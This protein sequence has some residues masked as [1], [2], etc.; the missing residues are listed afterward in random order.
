MKTFKEYLNE[1][2]Q[3]TSIHSLGWDRADDFTGLKIKHSEKINIAKKN[4]KQ[5][6]VGSTR[7]AFE[8]IFKGKPTVMKIAKNDKG[9]R[10]NLAEAN[11]YKK[12][13][14]KPPYAPPMIDWDDNDDA[15]TSWIHIMKAAK[16]NENTFSR[17]FKISFTLFSEVL[18]KYINKQKT[19]EMNAEIKKFIKFVEDNDL[20]LG[21]YRQKT[22]WGVYNNQPVILD[23]GVTKSNQELTL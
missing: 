14:Y 7:V 16:Y 17:F 19:D 3:K 4:A 18:S 23:A 15:D 1:S 10:Q 11:L 21:E 12:Y 5:I 2:E 22:N 13:K 20:M 9:L 6:G 8:I